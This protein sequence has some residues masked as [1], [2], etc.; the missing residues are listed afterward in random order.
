MTLCFL[1]RFWT[2]R[3]RIR[4]S[5]YL[6]KQVCA[7]ALATVALTSALAHA[8]VAQT[9][10]A[11]TTAA[12]TTGS[13]EPTVKQAAAQAVSQADPSRDASVIAPP[14][15][16]TPA[17]TPFSPVISGITDLSANT[18]AIR[19]VGQLRPSNLEGLTGASWLQSAIL[20][21][22]VSPGG[23]HWGWIY[24]GW[25]IPNGQPYLAI[26]R[27]AG[28]SMVRAYENLYTF[29]VLETK[30][31]GWI[32]V[33]YTP[34]G[35]AWVHNS[36]LNLGAVPLVFEGWQ[37]RLQAQTSVY[38]LESN[39]AQALRSQPQS[40]TNVLSLVTADSLIEPLAFQ[41]DWMQVRVTRPT[42]GC[43]P[44]TGATIAEG[45]ML[46]RGAEGEALAWYRPEGPCQL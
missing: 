10:A 5:T 22:Y 8:T 44:L 18:D 40:A 24:Q 9:T 38:F 12:Q 36:Q 46:W 19:S 28:F 32:R 43:Q 31:D 23:E 3:F 1:N 27:D 45:W 17:P 7:V 35:S 33:Q 21:L 39:K 16:P 13:A 2:K 4:R 34:A 14:P 25:L 11:Q 6:R 20:P 37:A 26:G 41:G 30:A 15:L 29:P 42:D